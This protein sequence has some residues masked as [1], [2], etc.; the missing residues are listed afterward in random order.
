MQVVQGA[1]LHFVRDL[2]IDLDSFLVLSEV[3]Q[4]L[5]I[6]FQ[7][8]DTRGEQLVQPTGEEGF[9]LDQVVHTADEVGTRGIH[10]HLLCFR[11]SVI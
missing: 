10:S 6:V 1:S 2:D 4:H 9:S 3:A 8:M 7:A 11:T 5:G